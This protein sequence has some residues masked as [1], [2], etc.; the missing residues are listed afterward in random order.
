MAEK[1]RGGGGAWR[2]WVVMDRWGGERVMEVDKYAIMERVEIHA[3]D[4]RVLDPS[5]SYPS[6]IL[7]RGTAI[8][9]NLQHIK[10]IITAEEVSLFSTLNFILEVP[11]Q[12]HVTVLLVQVLL[13]DPTDDAVAPVVEVLRGRLKATIV[14][15]REDIKDRDSGIANEAEVA[16]EDDS[17]FEFVALEVVLDGI[18]S[19]LV[20]SMIELEA[21]VYPALDILTTKISSRNLDR[22]HRLKSR[23]TRL[24]AQVQK[25]RDEL[26][27]L[28]NDDDDMS[29][30]YLSRKSTSTLSISGSVSSR[31][32]I[33]SSTQGSKLSRASRVSVASVHGEENEIEDLETLLEAYFMQIDST[34]NKL[35][36]LREY[37][38]NTE[39]YINIQLDNH[40]NQLIQ[41]ELFLNSATVCLSVYSLVAGIFGM[42]IPFTW[43]YNHS[44]MFKWVVI[45][46]SISCA[47]MFVFIIS[48]A[49]RKGLIGS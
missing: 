26:E 30:L 29:D 3:R 31:R 41:L 4:M 25:V 28:L 27:Q 13:R 8:V 2:R 40:R 22:V 16:E 12:A 21:E 23:M 35:S 20:A 24:T 43:N 45:I 5:L 14:N 38:D 1:R 49:R 36:T 18:C 46:T 15:H 47:A 11:L 19:Y 37:I 44:H 32:F 39:D 6:A 33:T 17:P 7:A 10:A 34:F 9:L 48:Y 42:N